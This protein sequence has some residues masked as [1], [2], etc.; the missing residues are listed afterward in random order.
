MRYF[1]L[2]SFLILNACTSSA[3][4]GLDKPTSYIATA[5]Q[6]IGYN[7]NTHRKELKAFMQIDPVRVEWCAAF[8]NAALRENGYSGSEYVTENTLLARGFLDYGVKVDE[9]QV[10]DIVVLRRGTEGWQGHV[11]FYVDQ[12]EI[13]GTLYYALL[14]GNNN[15]SVDIDW[16]STR[17][18][19]GVRRPTSANLLESQVRSLLEKILDDQQ[20]LQLVRFDQSQHNLLVP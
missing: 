11:G 8:I 15:E 3:V 5:Y 2:L 10:G 4:P 14:S 1:L 7:Q 16:F 20:S 9:P 17:K 13:N 19:I 12:K 6:Y 18:V